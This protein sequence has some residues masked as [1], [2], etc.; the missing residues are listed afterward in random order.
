MLFLCTDDKVTNQ[1]NNELK[2]LMQLTVRTPP[3]CFKLWINFFNSGYLGFVMWTSQPG[4]QSSIPALV[5]VLSR[6]FTLRIMSFSVLPQPMIFDIMTFYLIK[7]V[8]FLCQIKCQKW[9]VMKSHLAIG[10]TAFMTYTN[11]DRLCAT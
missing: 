1:Q 10:K 5:F 9:L 8:L 7:N 3:M 6:H 11:Y 4:C 2:K